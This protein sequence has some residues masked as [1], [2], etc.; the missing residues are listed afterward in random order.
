MKSKVAEWGNSNGIRITSAMMAHLNV[1]SGEELELKLTNKGIEIVKNKMSFDDIKTIKEEF[2][3]EMY[4]NSEPVKVL[5]NPYAE[6][7]VAYIVISLNPCRPEIREVAM[8]TADSYTALVDAKEAARQIVQAAIV[9]AKD[10]LGN[11]RQ[12]GIDN[13][14][15]IA[16]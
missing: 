12:L 13:I 1:K 3:Q 11:I 15:Y 7:D 6:T 8:G 14:N 10:S 5:S 2:L 4:K 9:E 16:L